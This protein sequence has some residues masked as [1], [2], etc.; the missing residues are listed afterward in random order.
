MDID[1]RC[2]DPGTQRGFFCVHLS[3]FLGDDGLVRE[4]SLLRPVDYNGF[5][6]LVMRTQIPWYEEARPYLHEH[7]QDWLGDARQFYS[8]TSDALKRIVE[9]ELE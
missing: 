4:L 2:C 9:H 8:L 7:T 1:G 3:R 6:E 5:V